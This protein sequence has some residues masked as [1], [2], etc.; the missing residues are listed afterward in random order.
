MTEKTE[1][2]DWVMSLLDQMNALRPYCIHGHHDVRSKGNCAPGFP[3]WVFIGARGIM[4]RENK[5]T[6]GT[7]SPAQQRVIALLHQSG[8][9]VA[10]RRPADRYSGLYARELAWLAGFTPSEGE[11]MP[12]TGMR[13]VRVGDVLPRGAAEAAATATGRPAPPVSVLIRAGLI[14]IAHQ[15]IPADDLRWCLER[16]T[17]HGGW[18][19][20]DN[21]SAYRAEAPEAVSGGLSAVQRLP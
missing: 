7:A 12:E 11:T 4:L 6:D 14:A 20:R 8:A 9:N 2:D 15:M 17:L 18:L 16:A 3:D 5:A 10:I 13:G 1:L 19:G 21:Q